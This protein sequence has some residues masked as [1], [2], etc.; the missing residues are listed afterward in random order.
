[1]NNLFSMILKIIVVILICF[2][3]MFTATAQTICNNETGSQGGYT[4]E[5]WKDNGTGCMVLGSGGA[6][7]IEWSNINNLLARK[8][9]RPGG[10]NV[11]V[12][13]SCS[14]NPNGN[15]YMCV[16]GWTRNPLVEYY[17]VD[18]WGTWRP[19]GGEGHQGTLSADG[20]SYDI[21]KT[22]RYDQ[23]SIDGPATF[24][25]YWSVRTSKKTSGTITC[26]NH[27]NAWASHGMNMGS[28][29]EV[30]FCI[31]GYQSSGSA[32][33]TSMSMST[34]STTTTT[35]STGSTPTPATTGN[36]V[37]RA[38]GTLGGENMELRVGGN[39]VASWTMTTSYQDYYADGSGTIAVY[40]TNDDQQESGRDIQ[41]D[42]IKYNNVTYQAE[43]QA[44]NTGVYQNSQCGGSNSEWLHCNGYIEFNTGSTTP[45]PTN[46]PTVTDPPTTTTT[47]SGGSTTTSSGSGGTCSPAT[48]KSVP[49]TQD[50][51]GEYC[52]STSSSINYIN[53]WNLAS[54]TVNGVDFTNTWAGGSGLP[55]KINGYYYI[56]YKSNYSWGHFEAN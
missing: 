44:T 13:Y 1:M 56:A 10:S 42:Y 55:A 49:F 6:F 46:P 39:V 4:Y 21:Y 7:S 8:G 37:V 16:Y 53:S 54:L 36:I 47:S 38:R 22:M 52:F 27:F 43:D 2:T 14:Y 26:A 48:S 17:I 50:G 45:A 11:I 3:S 25:Q 23:P 28:F 15:S 33:V 20:G 51:T 24:P 40:F 29:Y 9:L 41:V 30:S 12:N 34:G 5:Y 35:T 32:N 19:P 31:E 18:S